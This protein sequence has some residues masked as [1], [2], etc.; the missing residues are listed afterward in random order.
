M[1]IT[2]FMD[3]QLQMRVQ[4]LNLYHFSYK[5]GVIFIVLE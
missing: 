4:H 2:A 1:T 5:V 3:L